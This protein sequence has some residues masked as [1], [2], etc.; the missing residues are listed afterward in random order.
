[1]ISII[2]VFLLSFD[3]ILAACGIEGLGPQVNIY[4]DENCAISPSEDWYD[5]G[6][7]AW[8]GVVCAIH[9]SSQDGH[10][11]YYKWYQSELPPFN[12]YC[13][14]ADDIVWKYMEVNSWPTG[15]SEGDWCIVRADQGLELCKLMFG[16]TSDYR[17]DPDD[18]GCVH[19]IE[20][21][22]GE[23]HN[24]TDDQ[25]PA[26]YEC[27]EACGSDPR[28]DEVTPDTNNCDSS[29]NFNPPCTGTP[30][31]CSS[32]GNDISCTNAGC[33]WGQCKLEAGKYCCDI[34]SS[35]NNPS[36][37]PIRCSN[38]GETNCPGRCCGTITD[39]NVCENRASCE[40]TDGCLG[41]PSPCLSHSD[42]PSCT[43]AGCTWNQKTTTTS[44]T[45]TIRRIGGGGGCGR[46]CMFEM[47]GLGLLDVLRQPTA[48]IA[49]L[50]AIVIMFGALEFLVKKK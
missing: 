20:K 15:A 45:T 41:S 18:W 33:T 24:C 14:H 27:E 12:K 35:C 23:I 26:N 21:K 7:G 2:T 48:L 8:G 25:K 16:G 28:C 47:V 43:N 34:E 22:Q 13:M 49:V 40:W 29:C 50:I 3:V 31:P 39:P 6:W 46:E 19:C 1:M 42:E 37:Y 44:T 9:P 30:N 38:A 32:Y 11:G 36:V 17:W 4:W 5:F 10:E